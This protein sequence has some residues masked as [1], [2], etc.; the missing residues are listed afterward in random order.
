MNGHFNN[1]Y[2]YDGKNI[3]FKDIIFLIKALVNKNYEIYVG[4][5]SQ[6]IKD[7]VIFVTSICLYEMGRGGTYFYQKCREPSDKYKTKRM[8]LVEES[9]VAVNV[10]IK[11][12]SLGFKVK[13]VHLDIATKK[14]A[15]SSRFKKETSNIVKAYGFKPVLKPYAWASGVADWH[16]KR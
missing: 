7:K 11:L 15:Y 13:E 1:Y 8:R 3:I 4:S 5:D 10:A 12:R 2:T 9:F 14:S 6:V 16:T